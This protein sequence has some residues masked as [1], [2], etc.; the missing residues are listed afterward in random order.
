MSATDGLVTRTCSVQ[1]SAR[2]GGSVPLHRSGVRRA[3]SERP[4]GVGRDRHQL[5]SGQ[6]H[7]GGDRPAGCPGVTT[8]QRSKIVGHGFQSDLVEC[9]EEVPHG[10]VRA[11]LGLRPQPQRGEQLSGFVD[12]EAADFGLGQFTR[13]SRDLA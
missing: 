3:G 10:L 13:V 9:L 8:A 11:V 5:L 4:E 6:P 1:S 2:G 12:Q 7:R